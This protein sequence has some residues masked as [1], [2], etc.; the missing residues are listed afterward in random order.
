MVLNEAELNK[1]GEDLGAVLTPGAV[2]ALTGNLGAG[3]TTL[4]KAIARGLGVTDAVTSPTFSLIHEY[5]SGRLPFYHFDVYRLE[6]ESEMY[7]LGYEEYFF[8]EG[9]TLVE[10][11]DRIEGLLPENAIRVRLAYGADPETREVILEN[12][13]FVLENTVGGAP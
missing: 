2:V 9:V 8:S 10:W 12:N 11:A 4:A 7:E 6:D 5:R 13:A 1:I 3:K